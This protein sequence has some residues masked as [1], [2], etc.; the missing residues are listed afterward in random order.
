[1]LKVVPNCKRSIS[2]LVIGDC[3]VDHYSY[4]VAAKLSPEAPVPV[5]S[6]SREDKI[7]RAHV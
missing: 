1:M 5:V 2:M 6:V 4:G 7:G 3:I